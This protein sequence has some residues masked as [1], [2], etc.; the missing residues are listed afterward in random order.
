M[1]PA[2]RAS[3]ALHFRAEIEKAEAAGAQRDD[4]SLHLTLSDVDALKRDRT[5]PIT[6]IS[7]AGG[8]MRYLGVKVVQGGVS[9]SI[10]QHAGDPERR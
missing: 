10:L 8:T 6:D 1:K 7:F 4:M 2:K 5:L 9:A 3:A